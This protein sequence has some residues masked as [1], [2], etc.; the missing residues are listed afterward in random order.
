MRPIKQKDI[1][2]RR[3]LEA[4]SDKKRVEEGL[5][6]PKLFSTYINDQLLLQ[7]ATKK[8]THFFT[9]DIVYLFLIQIQRRLWGES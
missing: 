4:M 9:D 2:R 1:L 8:K 3:S 6:S 7:L 5:L